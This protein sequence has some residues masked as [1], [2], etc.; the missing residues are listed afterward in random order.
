MQ[1]DSDRAVVLR[2]THCDSDEGVAAYRGSVGAGRL[3][4]EDTILAGVE[5][6]AGQQAWARQLNSETVETRVHNRGGRLWVL[7]IKT[8]RTGTVIDTSEG[9]RTELVGGLLY[10]VGAV[11]EADAAFVTSGGATAV[12]SYAT[13][14]WAPGTDYAQHVRAGAGQSSL[15]AA[16]LPG[17]TA[18]GHVV[19]LHATGP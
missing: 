8:E 18:H 1:H 4:L 3:F 11:P 13:S 7:G 14:A 5:I 19:V 17:R 6:A 2:S 9:G 15:A 12:L 10:P 16:Q